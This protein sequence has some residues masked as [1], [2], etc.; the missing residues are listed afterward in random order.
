M[1]M[2]ETQP[3]NRAKK[4][5]IFFQKLFNQCVYMLSN[6]IFYTFGDIYTAY[7][8]IMCCLYFLG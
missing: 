7:F 6:S 2:R 5:T 3:D 4:K 8:D 1:A